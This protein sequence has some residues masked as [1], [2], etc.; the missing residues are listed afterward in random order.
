MSL[1]IG[2][3]QGHVGTATPV[4]IPVIS[5]PPTATLTAAPATGTT[6]TAL[7]FTGTAAIPGASDSETLRWSVLSNNGQNVAG[8]TGSTFAFTPT[9]AGQYIVT[10]TAA[11]QANLTGSTSTVVAVRTSRRQ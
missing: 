8:G 7:T 4:D 3:S 2:D 5:V 9:A 11:S 10:L 6:G 1:A